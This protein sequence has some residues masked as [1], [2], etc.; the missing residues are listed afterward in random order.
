MAI[1]KS[2][3]KAPEKPYQSEEYLRQLARSINALVDELA[4]IEDFDNI[5]NK[6]NNGLINAVINGSC[7]VSHR[8]SQSLSTSWVYGQVD[9]IAVKA[10]GTVSDGTIKQSTGD[11][12][13]SSSGMACMVEDATLTGDGAVIFRHRIEAKDARAFANNTAHFS[14][15]AYH[16]VGSAVNCIV[17]INKA[18][19]EDDFSSVT[20]IDTETTSVANTSYETVSIAVDDMGDCRNGI[21]IQVKFDCGAITTK[22]FMLSELQLTAGLTQKSFEQRPT[23]LEEKLVN[24]YLRPV[25][26]LVAVANSATNMQVVLEHHGMRDT[27]SYE[28]TGAL[29]MTDGVT[30]DFTQSSANIGTIHD[31]NKDHGR[32]DIGNFSGLTSGTFHIQRGTGG[33]ILASAEL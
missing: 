5:L 29:S 23:S 21:E 33:V 11:Y 6:P 20:Q 8:A 27:P 2:I 13:I 31:N 16:D 18:D 15:K 14:A 22:D 9:L 28:L 7:I 1:D 24:R 30:S 32:A 19:S 26:G 10:E 12:D 25:V 17:T 4:D 3:L